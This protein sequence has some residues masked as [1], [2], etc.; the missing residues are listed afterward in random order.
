M[1]ER[2]CFTDRYVKGVKPAPKGERREIYDTIVPGLMLRVTD[3]GAKSFAV[4]ARW[5]GKAGKRTIGPVKR[6]SLKEARAT[7]R[8]WLE[9]A[10][11]GKDPAEL[12]RQAR[13][14]EALTFGAV[15]EEFIKRHVSKLR[16]AKDMEREIRKELMPRFGR[17][18]VSSITRK[19]ITK[20]LR[21]IRDRGAVFQA[22]HVFGHVR[23]FYSWAMAQEDEFDVQASPCAGINADELI[24]ERGHRQR[25]LSD[26]EIRAVWKAA[27]KMAYPVG[28]LYRM[29]LLTGQRKTEVAGARWR[30]FDGKLW[31]IPSERFKSDKVHLV[32]LSA[33]VLELLEQLPRWTQGDHLFSTTDGAKPVNGF[34]KAKSRLDELMAEEL[35][36]EL[37]PWVIHDLRRTVRTRLSQ[38]KVHP[39]IA[40]LVIGHNRKGLHAVYD[41]HEALDERREALEAWAHKLRTIIES[42]PP[43]KVHDIE[44]ERRARA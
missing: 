4:N 11:E 18:P 27:T 7:A 16:K 19:D 12:V 17:R 37:E 38:L 39:E 8:K 25:V 5:A 36:R 40:E 44:E 20:M 29:L 32:P 28:T 23:K 15:M 13:E 14:A 35:G 42:P 24:G 31:T 3:K 43:G 41:Q 21:E 6:V 26:A 34:S 30:E 1:S 2:C 9:L 22:H 33:D 10:Q